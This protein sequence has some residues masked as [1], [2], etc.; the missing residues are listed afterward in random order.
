MSVCQKC[1]EYSFYEDI[2]VSSLKRSIML[3][4]IDLK[5]AE[6]KLKSLGYK[7]IYIKHDKPCVEADWIENT[8]K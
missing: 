7:K 1:G 5:N 3:L 6:D 4:E 2:D 8:D